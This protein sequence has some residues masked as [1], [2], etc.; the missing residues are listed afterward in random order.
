M[1]SKVTG[2]FTNRS[3]N[4]PNA[5]NPVETFEVHESYRSEHSIQHLK[6]NEQE[7]NYDFAMSNHQSESNNFSVYCPEENTWNIDN[8]KNYPNKIQK[9]TLKDPLFEARSLNEPKEKNS[10]K[11]KLFQT[12]KIK[13]IFSN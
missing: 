10:Q 5:K 11:K 9:M 13:K 4:Y 3:Q 8:L 6:K 12:N 1:E 2:I 7:I